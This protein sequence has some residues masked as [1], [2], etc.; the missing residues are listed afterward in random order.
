MRRAAGGEMDRRSIVPEDEVVRLPAMAISEA[1][2]TH[3]F[4]ELGKQAA[5]FVFGKPKDAGREA[6]L[7]KRAGRPVPGWMRTI[8]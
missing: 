1:R 6:S 2:R 8:G 4:E 3:M 7:T 5:A